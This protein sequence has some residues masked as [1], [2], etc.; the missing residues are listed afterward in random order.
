MKIAIVDDEPVWIEKVKEY[1]VMYCRD[2]DY[3]LSCFSSGEDFLAADKD[4]SIVF[5]DVEMP[6]MDGF[7]ALNEYR[8]LYGES[9][10]IIL[11]T[12][13]EFSRKGY[14]VAAFRYI[15]KHCLEEIKE[16]LES[17]I[18]RLRRY[19][20]VEI[21]IVSKE[22]LKVRCCDILYFDVYGHEIT[23]SVLNGESM[24]CSETLTEISARLLDKGFMLTDRSHLVNLDHVKAVEKNQVI[25]KTGKKIPMSRRKYDKVRKEYFDWRLQ[26]SN[27]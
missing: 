6:E 14:K 5:M 10:F 8:K 24:R 19:Q 1:I 13:I 15:D 4:F 3:E 11:T 12:H 17:A 23:M 9:I 2:I 22:I 27:G 21:P 25:M 18:F 26:A 16:A 20:I 7:F